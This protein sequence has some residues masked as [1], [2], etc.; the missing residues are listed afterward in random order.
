M[1]GGVTFLDFWKIIL[2]NKKIPWNWFIWIPFFHEFLSFFLF[3]VIIVII[4]VVV[5]S[6]LNHCRF[7]TIR[8]L[9]I[10]I[11]VIRFNNYKRSGCGCCSGCSSSCCCRR[12]R[13]GS[14]WSFGWSRP[15]SAGQRFGWYQDS[16]VLLKRPPKVNNILLRPPIVN[17][18]SAKLFIKEVIFW[19]LNFW[20]CCREE[21]N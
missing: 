11:I 8:I 20:N 1:Y 18:R 21:D 9:K 7:G 19:E 3:I 12:R 13:R 6:G 15:E 2:S 4:I 16:G 5:F 17:N 10:N 14:S